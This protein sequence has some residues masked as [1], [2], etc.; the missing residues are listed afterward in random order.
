MQ[1]PQPMQAFEQD[2]LATAPLSCELHST[3]TG[4]EKGVSSNTLCGQ[5]DTRRRVLLVV[6][7]GLGV[8]GLVHV[9]YPLRCHT[10]RSP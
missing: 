6:G 9:S 10:T 7:E 2:F 5:V 1:R 3:P 8:D 4:A